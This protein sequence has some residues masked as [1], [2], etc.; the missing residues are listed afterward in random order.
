MMVAPS[1]GSSR[2]PDRGSN[3]PRMPAWV[4]GRYRPIGPMSRLRQDRARKVGATLGFGI[5]ARFALAA[6]VAAAGHVARV[7]WRSRLPDGRRN[8]PRLRWMLGRGRSASSRAGDRD[9]GSSPRRHARSGSVS[10]FAVRAV[11]LGAAAVAIVV[12]VGA[13]A[14]ARPTGRSSAS[15]TQSERSATRSPW[16][17]VGARWPCSY[18]LAFVGIQPGSAP[19]SSSPPGRGSVRAS[20]GGGPETDSAADAIEVLSEGLAAGSTPGPAGG[21]RI[22]S[23]RRSTVR[24]ARCRPGACGS[25]WVDR[26]RASADGAAGLGD[27]DAAGHW[28]DPGSLG[29]SAPRLVRGPFLWR[30]RPRACRCPSWPSA[31]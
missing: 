14:E 20:V 24:L 1:C 22:S 29:W 9:R 18:G 7:G 19:S 11:L 5:P 8:G 3:C 28:R 4:F 27:R 15:R 25:S 23:Y 16:R 10:R 12:G 6:F 17:P 13:L 21:P 31:A 26:R 30:R 2:A